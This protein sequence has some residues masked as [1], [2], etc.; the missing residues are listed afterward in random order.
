MKVGIIG[1]GNIA[2]KAY[3]PTYAS[4]QDQHEFV[5]YSR[6][7]AKARALQT[8]YGF[9]GAVTDLQRLYDADLVFI[10]A[11]TQAHFTLAKDF[12]THG[13]PVFM[14]KPISEHLS[15]TQALLALAKEKK[16]LFISGF[17]RRFAPRVSELKTLS[18]KSLITVT[19]NRVNADLPLTYELYDLFIHPLDTLFFLLDDLADV[20]ELSDNVQ[21]VAKTDAAGQLQQIVVVIETPKTIGIAKLNAK[22]GANTETITVE[23]PSATHTLR[24][25]T[26]EE[27]E[28]ATST[29]QVSFS[30]WDTTLYKR[31]FESMVKQTLDEVAGFEASHRK[32]SMQNLKQEN[33]LKSHELID[34]ILKKI[35]K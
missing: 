32:A 21:V 23:T 12:L 3:F 9:S 8:Q 33:V 5:I 13:V 29:V 26:D 11:A 34:I 20:A 15:E 25:L 28:T 22:S 4:L 19:K 1:A 18:D 31:G 24:G 17:N 14:D 2:Q 6:D 10:H 30:D 16:L 7:L 27:I 35:N